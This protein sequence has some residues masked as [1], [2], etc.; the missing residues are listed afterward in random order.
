MS[1][2]DNFSGG[3]LLGTIIG[4]VVGGIIGTVITNNN[5][6]KNTNNWDEEINLKNSQYSNFD[7]EKVEHSPMSLEEKINQLNNAIDDVKISLMK[8]SEKEIID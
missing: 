2:K 3:F 6:K 8:N 7:N 4:G 1:Q 5:N